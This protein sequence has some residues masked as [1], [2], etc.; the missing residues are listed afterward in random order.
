M[1]SDETGTIVKLS[2]TDQTVALDDAD[3]RGRDVKD[4]NGEDL[5]KVD[6]LMIDDREHKVRFLRVAS[7]G[8]LGLGEKQSLIPVDAITA[9]T[10]DVVTISQDRGH[11]AGAPVYD[12]DLVEDSA[13][14]EDVY[15]YYGYTPF[16]GIGYAYPGYPYYPTRG[17]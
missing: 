16:W 17:I 5:G 12:P 10:A 3:V 13:Y 2:D 11:V 8:F 14:Y 15:G 6:D 9:V 4:K 7:G 1:A